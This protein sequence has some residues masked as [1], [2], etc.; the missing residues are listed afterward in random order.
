MKGLCILYLF[1]SSVWPFILDLEIKATERYLIP[2]RKPEWSV[3]TDAYGIIF[4]HPKAFTDFSLSLWNV[5][6][7]GCSPVSCGEKEFK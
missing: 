3:E 7:C 6:I 2:H 1:K 4:H 5:Y